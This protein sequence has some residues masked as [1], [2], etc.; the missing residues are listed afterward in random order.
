METNRK[1]LIIDDQKDLRE[2]LAKL[3]K[4]SG[5]RNETATLV[6]LMRQKMMGKGGDEEAEYD[7][8]PT[9][10]VDVAGQGEEGYNMV[11]QAVES[12]DPYAI[13]FLDMRMPPGWDGLETAKKLREV[14]KDL[15]IV[16]MT[17]YADHDQMTI[18][19]AV[20]MPEKLLYIKKP[21]QTEEIFQLALSLTSKWSLEKRDGNKRKWL[22]SLA[23]CMSRIQY[24]S[25]FECEDFFKAVLRSL[26]DFL[27]AQQGFIAQKTEGGAWKV[28]SCGGSVVPAEAEKFLQENDQRL[29]GA[30]ATQSFDGKYVLPLKKDTF[31]AVAVIHDSKTHND[32]EWFKILSLLLMSASNSLRATLSMD[33]D[34][35]A[36]VEERTAAFRGS[37][38][39][40]LKGV[41][42]DA[43]ALAKDP[44][45]PGK[46]DAVLAAARSALASCG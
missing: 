13:V 2:Q 23:R 12:N 25:V 29:A 3:L 16:I 7:D 19:D 39:A 11:R 33:K 17:A 37:M 10:V 45:A 5:K 26:C 31:F 44:A 14:D 4:R 9:Y 41:V 18:A 28:L 15:E 1:I 36:K 34:I 22:E 30:M 8:E 46:L 38:A 24:T 35:Q 27:E 42:A 32:P 21:F 6:Q 40:S 43:E 20:G